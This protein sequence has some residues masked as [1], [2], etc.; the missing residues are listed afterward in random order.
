MLL[1]LKALN[2]NL[3]LGPIRAFL[4]IILIAYYGLAAPSA[5]AVDDALEARIKSM[6]EEMSLEQK[7]GQMVQGEIKWVTPADVTKYHLGSVLN[8]GGSFPEGNKLATMNDWLKLADSYYTASLDRSE[9]GAGIP[10]IWGTD[11]VHGHNNVIGATLFPHNIG[12]GAARDPELLRQIGQVTAREVAVTGIDWIF[13]PTVAVVQDFRWGR[14]YEGYTSDAQLVKSYAE[15]I[16]LGMQGTLDQLRTDDEKVVATAKHFIGDGGTHRGIDQGD[17]RLSLEQLIERHGQGY[18]S[19]IDAGVQTVMASFNSWNGDKIHGNKTLL[20]DVLKGQMGFDGFVIG[21]WNGHGQVTGCTNESC[22]RS[23][24]A[25]VDMIM[26]PEDWKELLLNTL[27]DVKTG[28]IAMSRIDDAVTRILRVKIRAG[29][30][31]KGLPSSRKVAGN[32]DLI[33]AEAHRAVARDAVRKSLVLLKNSG[34]ILPLKAGQHVLVTGDAA[35]NIGKQNGGWTITWQGTENTN[36]NFPGATSVFG[37][38]QEALQTIGSSAELSADGSWVK[39]PDVAVVVFGE[40]PYAEGVGDI[41]SLAYKFGSNKDLRLLR[42]LREQGIPVVSIFLTGRPLAVNAEL[43][44]SDAFVVAWLPGTEGQGISDVIVADK[45]G[46]PRF[47][48]TGRLPFDWPNVEHNIDDK[49]LPVADNILVVGDG[50]SFGDAEIIAQQLDKGIAA[51]GVSSRLV[52][53]DR[54]SRAPFSAFVGDKSDWSRPLDGKVTKSAYGRLTV[55]AVDGDVQEDSLRAQ[56]SGRRQSQFFWQSEEALNLKKISDLNGA[57]MV[58]FM[59]NER[60]RGKVVQ[61]LDC[62]WPCSASQDVT[63]VF[64]TVPMGEWVT[65]GI[66]LKC[67]AAAGAD[68]E[69]VIVPFLL[70]TSRPFDIT[71]KNVRIVPKAPVD[72]IEYCQL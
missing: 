72:L 3:V 13:A 20:T 34:D 62:G 39:K 18:L 41:D 32:Q 35:D 60:P 53:F 25:G 27:Q 71:I 68:V 69:R 66:S 2:M 64:K 22:A 11:A 70:T 31:N 16:V 61:R 38:I 29:L 5:L 58:E 54:T 4:K 19:A 59:V 52:V 50:L 26:V 63:K 28:K 9:G 12:L 42:K 57:I 36:S 15:Q 51:S 65:R 6:V 14:A 10:I 37:G 67:F 46:Q 55:S 21:D 1:E 40:E 56:W 17:T 43:N 47:D 44:A 8:G 45:N 33:G 23:I 7:V 49:D 30:F 48:F 24:N